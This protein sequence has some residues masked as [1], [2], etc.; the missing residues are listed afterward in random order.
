MNTI[1]NWINF[2]YS[3][4]REE[5]LSEV[6]EFNKSYDLTGTSVKYREEQA[7]KKVAVLEEELELLGT[8]QA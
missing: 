8:G 5:F 7:K 4:Y 1:T 6:K 2:R 3:Y